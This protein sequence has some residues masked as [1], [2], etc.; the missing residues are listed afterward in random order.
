MRKAAGL[1]GI[2]GS[3]KKQQPADTP[4]PK[5]NR[6]NV[7]S[8]SIPM[9][10]FHPPPMEMQQHRRKPTS[11]ETALTSKNYRLAKELVRVRK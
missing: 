3:R 7:V 10:P 6:P 1:G 8:S 2:R 4:E 5:E 9:E 11:E